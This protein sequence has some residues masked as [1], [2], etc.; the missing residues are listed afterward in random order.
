MEGKGST[1]AENSEMSQQKPELKAA[2]RT[3]GEMVTGH[4][5]TTNNGTNNRRVESFLEMDHNFLQHRVPRLSFLGLKSA[6]H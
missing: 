4:R 5:Y 6:M 1:G 2:L 3:Y